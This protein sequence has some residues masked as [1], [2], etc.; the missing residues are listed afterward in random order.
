MA[1]GLKASSCDPLSSEVYVC[2]QKQNIKYKFSMYH[3]Y[4]FIHEYQSIL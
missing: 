4:L 1:Y 2:W 3:F